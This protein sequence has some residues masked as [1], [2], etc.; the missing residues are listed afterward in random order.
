MAG[1]ER[2]AM[3]ALPHA[4]TPLDDAELRRLW[5]RRKMRE[6][7]EKFGCSQQQVR[8]RAR[9][10]RLPPRQVG[11]MMGCRLTVVEPDEAEERRI[12]VRAR[13]G[14]LPVPQVVNAIL[15][16]R[17][18]AEIAR[19]CLSEEPTM[20]AENLARRILESCATDYLSEIELLGRCGSARQ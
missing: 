9:T 3:R 19:L 1:S 17:R 6:L 8:T 20:R 18:V 4:W 15:G 12:V 2:V 7:A 16:M 14:D 5:S 10:L 11:N 13:K